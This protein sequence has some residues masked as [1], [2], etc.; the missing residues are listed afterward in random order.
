MAEQFNKNI[1]HS[2]VK[3]MKAKSTHKLQTQSYARVYPS[4][5]QFI[6]GSV[7]GGTPYVKQVC[8]THKF[9]GK[10]DCGI[11]L[12]WSKFIHKSLLSYH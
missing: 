10:Q 12:K 1:D 8:S 11:K 3:D 5:T 2:Y 7:N 9:S 4:G 6:I